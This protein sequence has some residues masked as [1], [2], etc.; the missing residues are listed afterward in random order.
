M[1]KKEKLIER[2]K[3][4][5]KDFKYDEL[6]TTLNFLGFAENNKGKTSGYRVAF[7]NGDIVI[8]LHKPHGSN[9]LKFYQLKQIVDVLINGGIL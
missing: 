1:S 6:C 8:T 7:S 9:N 5:P 2:L 3:L 4:K